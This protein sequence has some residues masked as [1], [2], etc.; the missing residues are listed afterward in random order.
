MG[1]LQ[2]LASLVIPLTPLKSAE[3]VCFLGTVIFFTGA[4][5]DVVVDGLM[6]CQ[7]RLN[8]EN[9]SEELQTYSWALVGLGGVIGGL[10]GGYLTQYELTDVV[11]YIIACF[12]LLVAFT[13]CMMNSKIE[14]SSDR[15][16]NMSLCQRTRSNFKDLYKGFKIKEL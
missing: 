12:G 16:I 8:K 14:A 2:A 4:V 7:S 13:A 5:M 1:I 6:V 15:I 9:G 3:Y 11:F 10:L